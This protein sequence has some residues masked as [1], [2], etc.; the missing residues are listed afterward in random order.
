MP[1]GCCTSGG[2]SARRAGPSSLPSSAT[3]LVAG[4][5]PLPCALVGPGSRPRRLSAKSR[6][7]TALSPA[8]LAS[9]LTC[10]G[11]PASPSGTPGGPG[12]PR[13]T[14]SFGHMARGA[15]RHFG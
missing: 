10:S 14:R 6:C 5:L 13:L 4:S 12:P 3:P 2:S 15:P 11:S 9:R 7:L 1:A 8:T